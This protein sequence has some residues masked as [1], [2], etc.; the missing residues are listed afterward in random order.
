MKIMIYIPTKHSNG[1]MERAERILNREAYIKLLLKFGRHPQMSS[2]QENPNANLEG[3]KPLLDN[4][5]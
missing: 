4:N 3:G 5:Q 2:K 1:R